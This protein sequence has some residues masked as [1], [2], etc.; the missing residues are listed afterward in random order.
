MFISAQNMPHN[1]L[2]ILSE[3][4][5]ISL[6]KDASNA[7]KLVKIKLRFFEKIFTRNFPENCLDERK[8]SLY[9]CETLN[10]ISEDEQMMLSKSE[11]DWIYLGLMD[12]INGLSGSFPETMRN[13]LN[14][15]GITIK[16]NTTANVSLEFIEECAWTIERVLRMKNFSVDRPLDDVYLHQLCSLVFLKATRESCAILSE[17]NLLCNPE[18]VLKQEKFMKFLIIL[19][20]LPGEFAQVCHRELMRQLQL[21]GG[22]R[23]LATNIVLSDGDNS[24]QWKK[25][26]TLSKIVSIP[27]HGAPFYRFIVQE[28]ANVARDSIEKGEDPLVEASIACLNALHGAKI[29]GVKARV[30]DVYVGAVKK[31]SN[32]EES[33][34]GLVVLD[35]KSLDCLLKL[36]SRAFRSSV[37]GAK[38][39]ILVGILP[40]LFE[41]H[42]KFPD[43]SQPQEI[44][45][46]LIVYC[47]ANR[48]D[49]E[50][51]KLIEIFL[52]GD[53]HPN[54]L[55][56]HP[57]IVVREV[58]KDEFA[59]Q[60]G[61]D[62]DPQESDSAGNL[63]KIL[64]KSNHNLLTYKVFKHLLR[65]FEEC[66]KD[67]DQKPKLDLLEAEDIEQ[68]L[69][70]T[71]KRRTLLILSLSELISYQPIH[72]LLKENPQDIVPFVLGAFRREADKDITNDVDTET[73]II[74]M[75]IFREFVTSQRAESFHNELRELLKKINLRTPKE[76]SQY[77][78]IF[79]EEIAGES[80]SFS[81]KSK[82]QEARLL[83]DEKMP[84]IRVY[85]MT[86]M[87]KLIE[88]K[89]VET[90]ANLH[91]TF[92]IVLQYLTDEDSYTFLTCIRLLVLL[93]MH[94]DEA[95]L[96]TLVLEYENQDKDID[97]RLKL[98]EA[99]VKI[100]EGLGPMAFK[101]KGIL[102]NCFLRGT[103][104]VH[105]EFR[106]SAL[107]NLGSICR[108]L[109]FQIHHFFNEMITTIHGILQTDTYLPCR[110][111][112]TLILTQILEGVD[113]L[114]DFQEFL[115]PTYRLLK[116]VRETET[117]ER[118]RVHA[119][120]GLKVLNAKV[121]ES[122]I[123]KE[124]RMQKEIKI[125]GIKDE[126]KTKKA[127]IL[128][129]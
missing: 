98:G 66:L 49:E 105:E 40:L 34:T 6:N 94:L 100:M 43:N 73:V 83:C 9:L 33:L 106:T 77:I 19:T 76:I 29:N 111:A 53:S 41:L 20:G 92:H 120:N 58:S 18:A 67:R 118:C 46:D 15:V 81:V 121:R 30:E 84:H 23:S 7:E 123:P 127:S 54:L 39:K 51:D 113:N 93:T 59:V 75:S 44:L 129:L 104:N 26:E 71:F 125:F 124:E 72:F 68:V 108:L 13:I 4:S 87:I 86:E 27:G 28:I 110:R 31:L 14:K 32:P 38:S 79:L 102:I 101:F 114:M 117:D 91:S 122:L 22:F 89:D 107:Y 57:R 119:E 5:A 88:Q 35:H 25:C 12:L 82:F 90:L 95:A 45:Q 3:Y 61:P 96:D 63:M 50:L 64:K 55:K 126:E 24:P 116:N 65:L 62:G 109:T 99:I 8:L 112:A 36:N 128:E 74:L 103:R 78:D 16:I 11:N 80:K 48:T 2:Q 115:L 17:K 42:A 1:F 37:S 97:F 56:L 10:G 60:L 69:S 85:G 52:F 47:L 70:E 21:P